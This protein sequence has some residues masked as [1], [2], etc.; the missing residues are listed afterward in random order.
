[1]VEEAN[2]EPRIQ[3]DW[4]ARTEVFRV[5]LQGREH[6]HAIEVGEECFVRK[7][8]EELGLEAETA[9]YRSEDWWSISDQSITQVCSFCV[10]VLLRRESSI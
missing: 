9:L 2:T 10:I 1:M 3:T 8:E 4:E 7:V 6:V 5:Y